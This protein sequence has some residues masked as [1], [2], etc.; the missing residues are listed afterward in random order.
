M[1]DDHLM[2]TGEPIEP[3]RRERT[4][5]SL[6]GSTRFELGLGG[7]VRVLR[8][9][10]LILLAVF[11]VAF[12]AIYAGS[13]LLQKRYSSVA[14]VRI[15]D[16]AQ[17]VF[18]TDG[19]K[20]DLSKEQRAVIL[21]LES[22]PLRAALEKELGTEFKNVKSVAS[23]G[24]EASPLIRVDA[25]ATSPDLARKAAD[26]TANIVVS[27]RQGKVRAELA[28]QADANDA[29]AT[30]LEGEVAKLT[31]DRAGVSQ[32]S[33]EYATATAK[34]DAKN[35]EFNQALQAAAKQRTESTTV[36]GGLE[37]YESATVPA[38][39][40]FPKPMSW[41]ILGGLAAVL[42]AAALVYG[43]EELVG[44]FHSG[45]VSESRRA[46]A[47]VLGVLPARNGSVPRGVATGAGATID[48]VGLQLVHLLGRG[49][50]NVVLLCGVDG[51]APENTSRR[52]AQSIAESGARVVYA[53]C[54]GVTHVS[55]DD[56]FEAPVPRARLSVVQEQQTG[57]RLRVLDDGIAVGELTVARARTVLR[58]LTEQCE[59]VVIAGPSP[60]I[61]PATLV[62]AELADATVMIAEHGVTRLRDAERAGTR[63][64]RVGGAV[65]GVLVDPARPGPASAASVPRATGVSAG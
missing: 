5:E 17:N 56:E 32:A 48:E 59:Y 26:V 25:T 63:L 6:G 10:G 41:A 15:N 64:R 13:T 47:R 53:A 18:V 52:I 50:P 42:L 61:E 19:G 1:I 3:G 29:R 55:D 33:A 37:V 22:P 27:D 57:G 40:D 35:A 2:P 4:L 51:P 24:L 46:G 23:T 54:R 30:Q 12:G 49:K 16:A 28:R 44:R 43:R 14:W 62:L 58:R 60:T 11:V 9:R 39:P 38:D 7:V 34:L 36:D 8:R 65:L 21:T 45:D 20:V 31:S